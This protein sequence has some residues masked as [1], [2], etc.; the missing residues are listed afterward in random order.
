MRMPVRGDESRINGEFVLTG[1]LQLELKKAIGQSLG[2]RTAILHL[3]PLSMTE[4]T[5]ACVCFDCLEAYAWHGVLPKIY[6]IAGGARW[7]DTELLKTRLNR[8]R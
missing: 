1:S 5:Q 6:Q 7:V 8:R 2:G 3:L 4:L